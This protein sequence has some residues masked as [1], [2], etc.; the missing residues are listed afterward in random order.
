MRVL[1]VLLA[2][3][4]ALAALA[5]VFFTVV[6]VIA[7]GLAAYVLQWFRRGP[8]PAPVLDR[9]VPRPTDDVIDVVATDVPDKPAG[10]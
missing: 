1:R 5:A 8:R 7:T 6:L 2:G 3:L 10:P 4:V 9:R